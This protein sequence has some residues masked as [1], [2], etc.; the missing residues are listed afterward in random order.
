MGEA[1]FLSRITPNPARPPPRAGRFAGEHFPSDVFVGS[2]LG[3]LIG[4]YVAHKNESGFPIRTGKLRRVENAVLRH[5]SI[6][7]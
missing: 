3:Y 4:D 2:I 1:L 6:G 7:N 5:L